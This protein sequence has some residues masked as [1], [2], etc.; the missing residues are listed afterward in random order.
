MENYEVAVGAVIKHNDQILIG[1][2]IKCT[3]N[4]KHPI[5]EEWHLPGGHIKKGETD[6][7]ALIREIQEETGI[8]IKVLH[9]IDKTIIHQQKVILKWYLCSPI[10]H[11]LKAG[12]DLTAVKYVDKSKVQESCGPNAIKVWPLK[13]KSCFKQ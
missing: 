9:Y 4:P 10:T 11:D 1:K 2:K 3:K 12:D 13:V 5:S 6:E 8:K 7:E